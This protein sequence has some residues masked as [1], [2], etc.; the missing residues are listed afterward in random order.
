MSDTQPGTISFRTS[1]FVDTHVGFDGQDPSS[2]RV[3]GDRGIFISNDGERRTE[4][5]E[6]ITHKKRRF[7][8]NPDA[9][10]DVLANWVP[11]AEDSVELEDTS[12]MDSV[13]GGVVNPDS[14]KRKSYKSSV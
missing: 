14:R 4:R 12:K 11:L 9:L 5:L 8:L 1:R 2:S 7:R 10:D 6:N 13:S 3:I